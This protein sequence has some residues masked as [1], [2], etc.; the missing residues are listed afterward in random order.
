[1]SIA[2]SFQHES[3]FYSLLHSR[4]FKPHLMQPLGSLQHC[5]LLLFTL[6]WD[7]T[8]PGSHVAVQRYPRVTLLESPFAQGL[9]CR[10]RT[11]SPAAEPGVGSM[12][13]WQDSQHR[14]GS[15]TFPS[16]LPGPHQQCCV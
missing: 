2:P 12:A 7:M 4:A 6:L 1:M 9:R 10:H 8:A 16:K 5:C 15:S 11:V 14:A 3:L 13:S